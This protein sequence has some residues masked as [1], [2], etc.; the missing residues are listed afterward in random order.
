[1]RARSLGLVL[2]AGCF[3]EESGSA[4][5]ATA[6]DTSA[7]TSTATMSSSASEPTTDPSGDPTTEST[8][9][10]ESDTDADTTDGEDACPFGSV[11]VPP[12]PEGW[13][14]VAVITAL[15]SDAPAPSCPLQLSSTPEKFGPL[16]PPEAAC[17]CE[18]PTEASELCTAHLQQDGE[19]AD[20]A[21]TPLVALGPECVEMTNEAVLL[22]ATANEIDPVEQPRYVGDVLYACMGEP[23]LGC[24][25]R[26]EEFFGPCVYS[27]TE[28][29]CPDP[30]PM[31]FTAWTTACDDC[32]SPN[33]TTLCSSLRFDVFTS[34]DC[35]N[36]TV[37]YAPLGL[38]VDDATQHS[39]RLG[40]VP[41]IDCGVTTGTPQST[42][43]CCVAE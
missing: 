10:T 25:P 40:P 41:P 30:Y 4:D 15:P 22:T 24:A 8:S 43:V 32:I 2:I 14:G 35:S 13:T 18:C 12:I 39:G 28:T 29:Q 33:T 5:D 1:M 3:Q 17:D 31:P 42:R 6:A 7:G 16:M 38:C 9:V 36:A 34:D 23:E 26:P 27:A 11:R 20:I 19:C 21:N 37:A